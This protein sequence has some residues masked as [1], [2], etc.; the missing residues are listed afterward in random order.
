MEQQKAQQGSEGLQLKNRT[1]EAVKN[2]FVCNSS[3]RQAQE[4]SKRSMTGV[5]QKQ[6]KPQVEKQKKRAA[7][8]TNAVAAGF[9]NGEGLTEEE[10]VQKAIQQSLS[11][12]IPNQQSSEGDNNLLVGEIDTKADAQQLRTDL[13][14]QAKENA[15]T[16][17]EEARTLIDT[18][19]NGEAGQGCSDM[20][21]GPVA[22]VNLQE[23]QKQDANA[24]PEEEFAKELQKNPKKLVTSERVRL[25]ME[26]WA[27]RQPQEGSHATSSMLKSGSAASARLASRVTEWLSPRGIEIFFDHLKLNKLKSSEVSEGIKWTLD[28]W[29]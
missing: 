19:C 13:E 3:K 25:L 29:N 23:H 21:A 18:T 28:Q 15:V 27:P 7:T 4:G 17:T 8:D 2:F 16:A 24:F 22:Q 11:P 12:W 9:A 20:S 26:K 1:W 10:Q 6:T 14:K 5:E